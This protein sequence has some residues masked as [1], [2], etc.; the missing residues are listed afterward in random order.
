MAGDRLPRKVMDPKKLASLLRNGAEGTLVIDSRSFVEYNSWH[1]LSSVNICCSKLVKR[2][3]Q[4]DKVSI[5]ELIQPASKMKVEAEDHQDVVVYDQSTRDVTGLAADSFLSILLGKLDSC[6]HSVSILTGGF[7][8]FSSCF[9]GLCEGKP[10]AILPMSI[11]QPCLPVANVGPTRILPHLYLG[12]QKDVLNKDLM[13]QN[14]ISYVLNASNSCPKPD[15]ICDSH[16]M[17][18]PVNDNYCEKLLPWLDK[19]IEFIDK[20][21]VSSCQVIV[22]CLAGISRSA[23]IAIAYIMKTMGM[24]SDDAYRFVKD[25]RPSIS[26]NFNFL[27]QLLEYER[28]LKLLKALKSKG[29]WSEGDTQQDPA[30]VAESSRH[31]L[32]P[33]SEKAEDVPRS[34]GSA[35][36][37][38]DPERQGGTP[39][40]LSPTTLQ[41]GL[42]GLHL[43]SERIQDTNRL[44]RSFSLDIKS[45]YSPG[46]RQDPPGPPGPGEAPK[47]CKLDSPSGSGSLSPF[48]PGADSPDRPTGPELLLEAKVRQ[49]RKHRHAAGSPAHGL[50][51]NVGGTC[52]TRKSPG[53]EDGLPPRLSQPPSA[54][55]ATTAAWSGVH[56]ESP[57]AASGE[58][59]WYFGKDSGSA[60]GGG[61]GLFPSAGPYPPPFGCGAA[62]AG[63]EIRLRDKARAEPRDGRHS[64][65]E[66]AGAEKQFKRRSCQMEFEETMSE[67][68]AREELGKISKQSSFSGSME[69]I[70]VS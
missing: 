9:P 32:T 14:G 37:T 34:S 61:G 65:H 55:G 66:E 40:V 29:D 60:G 47:L 48:S 58:A 2:R 6:F 50:S 12:S 7:A 25:R 21:K 68:R 13:T 64:W 38:S 11:S 1:V 53:A 5:T 4:Q 67:G 41:Q 36:P 39:K 17:R 52:A 26:P 30:E 46:L 56:L 42:N 28:S 23:T 57:G 43:S 27:G 8:T 19:S 45:A 18:I 31:P 16:F 69:I 15:F 62:A 51:L 63:C 10:A 59:G 35:S 20:A 54:P 49:R 22:H 44:K 3:L 33:T 24:S 70:E